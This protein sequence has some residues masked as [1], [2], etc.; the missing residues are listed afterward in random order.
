[1]VRSIPVIGTEFNMLILLASANWRSWPVPAGGDRQLSSK[2]V[3]YCR[4]TAR[5]FPLALCSH[6]CTAS[7][8]LKSGGN[9]P[10]ARL[11]ASQA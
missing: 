10:T 5:L 11:R 4:L 2:P 8:A 9:G 6:R 7:G 1:M 3:T